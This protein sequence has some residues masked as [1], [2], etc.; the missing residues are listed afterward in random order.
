MIYTEVR[1]GFSVRSKGL[2]NPVLWSDAP[3]DASS[4]LLSSKIETEYSDG[5]AC[6]TASRPSMLSIHQNPKKSEFNYKKK[7]YVRLTDFI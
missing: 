1:D 4:L 7:T 6:P 5:E 3:T 2:T